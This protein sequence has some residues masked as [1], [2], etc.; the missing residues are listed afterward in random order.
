M[1][2][3]NFN[4]GQWFGTGVESRIGDSWAESSPS[5]LRFG[6]LGGRGS[7]LSALRL[8]LLFLSGQTINHMNIYSVE[9]SHAL[10]VKD[11]LQPLPEGGNKQTHPSP[12]ASFRQAFFR[13]TLDMGDS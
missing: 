6:G 9:E 8:T 1:K 2:K 4:L 10:T 12:F 3:G 7:L 11:T 13:A 5:Y